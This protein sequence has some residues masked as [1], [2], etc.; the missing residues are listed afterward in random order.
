MDEIQ[1]DK[2]YSCMLTNP[3]LSYVGL[4][5]VFTLWLD[6][7]LLPPSCYT[8]RSFLSYFVRFSYISGCRSC[9]YVPMYPFLTL[10]FT[11]VV[12]PAVTARLS[13]TIL[14]FLAAFAR[15]NGEGFFSL[16]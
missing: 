11:S 1:M 3:V 15:A 2:C 10:L 12:V 16:G 5:F 4:V 9:M 14:K 13:G 6:F 8:S 7:E